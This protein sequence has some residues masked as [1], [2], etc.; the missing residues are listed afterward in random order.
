MH[1]RQHASVWLG[2]QLPEFY[3]DLVCP[4]IDAEV[5]LHPEMP[6]IVLPGLVHL[7]VT[8]AVLVPGRRRRRDQRGIN[9]GAFR[10][11]KPFSAQWTIFSMIGVHDQG[12]KEFAS[13]PFKLQQP[14]FRI[15]FTYYCKEIKMSTQSKYAGLTAGAALLTASLV[16][17]ADG[18]VQAEHLLQPP[19]TWITS[20]QQS[21]QGSA[22]FIDAQV[23]A[24]RVFQPVVAIGT[25]P[26]GPGEFRASESADPQVQAA[27]M[28]KC[29]C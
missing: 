18:Q 16:A 22:E 13:Y 21:G 7:G 2:R 26:A 4:R 25:A 1:K 14:V 8:L 27:R 29:S 19:S 9:N 24:Q 20:T 12:R 17:N 10:R 3:A 23:Q 28:L 11:N 6:L 15:A 5:R